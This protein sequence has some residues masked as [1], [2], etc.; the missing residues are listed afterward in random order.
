MLEHKVAYYRQCEK[1]DRIL[2]RIRQRIFDYEDM[3]KLEK[4]HRIMGKIKDHNSKRDY[5]RHLRSTD[6]MMHTWT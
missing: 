4:A 6:G 5:N 3:G 1:Y 2:R